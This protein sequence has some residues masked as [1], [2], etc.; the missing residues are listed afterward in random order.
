[1][2]EI[3]AILFGLF[4]LFVGITLFCAPILGTLMDRKQKENREEEKEE[5][6]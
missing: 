1:M 6:K 4:F 2:K 5:K 3:I